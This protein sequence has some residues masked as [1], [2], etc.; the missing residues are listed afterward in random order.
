MGMNND[1]V[2]YAD[3]WPDDREFINADVSAKV[4]SLYDGVSAYSIHINNVNGTKLCS[5]FVY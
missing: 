2:A 3:S 1:I 4:G 5:S